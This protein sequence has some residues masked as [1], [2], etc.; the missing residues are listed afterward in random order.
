MVDVE[1]WV[2]RQESL[3]SVPTSSSVTVLS[4][5]LCS[6]IVP[7]ENKEE[8]SGGSTISASSFIHENNYQS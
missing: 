4:A 1:P 7:P 3:S 8:L 2:R 6:L 5:K